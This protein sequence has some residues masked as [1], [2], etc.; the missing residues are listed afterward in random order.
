MI[1][2]ILSSNFLK[3]IRKLI[4]IYFNC[5]LINNSNNCK[6]YVKCFQ[7]PYRYMTYICLYNFSFLMV[8]EVRI[9]MVVVVGI[10]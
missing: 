1:Y 10:C 3:Q 8:I 6:A 5:N 4:K 7:D 9:R 2:I